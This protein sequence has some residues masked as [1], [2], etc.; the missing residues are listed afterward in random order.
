MSPRKL[1]RAQAVD[2][3]CILFS[4]NTEI[5]Q[6]QSL[7]A[8]MESCGLVS[9][10]E[11]FQ[12]EWFGFVH[13]A[14]VTSLMVHAPNSV[15]VDYLRSTRTLLSSRHIP[16]EEAKAFVDTHFAHYMEILGKEEQKHCPQFFFKKVYDIENIEDVPSRALALISATMAMLISSV[17]DK[18]EQYD[19]QV[20]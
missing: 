13:A 18:I 9:S 11:L 12:R 19:I 6:I 14:I 8:Q 1:S 3:A 4:L 7:I 2:A 5:E 16:K 10:H 20:D 17:T 15:L